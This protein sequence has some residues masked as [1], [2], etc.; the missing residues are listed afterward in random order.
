MARKLLGLGGHVYRRYHQPPMRIGVLG[1]GAIGCYLG[2][3]L[4]AAGHDVVL[5][6]RPRVGEELAK[7][8]LVLTDYT[9]AR[10]SLAP[11]SVRFATEPA[12]LADRE[13]V[14]VTVK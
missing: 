11:G 6:G 1:A 2:G 10:V 9:G 13:A 5:V 7:H 4:Q 12:A 3:R 8:G 14:L